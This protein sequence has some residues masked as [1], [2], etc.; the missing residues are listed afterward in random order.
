MRLS[1]DEDQFTA[2][3]NLPFFV[4]IAFLRIV[5]LLFVTSY[6]DHLKREDIDKAGRLADL[7]SAAQKLHPKAHWPQVM[8]DIDYV[9]DIIKT[10]ESGGDWSALVGERKEEQKKAPSK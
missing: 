4:G 8:A 10:A 6:N 1:Y 7:W 2:A 3:M 5:P 9:L